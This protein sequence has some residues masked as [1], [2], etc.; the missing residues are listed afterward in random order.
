[1]RGDHSARQWQVI[2]AIEA[3]SKGLTAAEIAG[4]DEARGSGQNEEALKSLFQKLGWAFLF[5]S[6]GIFIDHF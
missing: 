5:I 2:R 6:G 1:M 4:P 3:S